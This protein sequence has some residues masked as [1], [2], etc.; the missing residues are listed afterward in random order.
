MFS[1]LRLLPLVFL[2]SWAFAA[3]L[4]TQGPY[5]VDSEGRVVLLRGLNVAGHAKV[6]PFVSIQEPSELDPL[7]DWGMNV[8]RL[9]FTWEAYEPKPG[10]YR[11][12]YLEHIR[13]TLQWAEERGIY[14]IVDF[15]Q[16]AYSRYVLGG[17]GEG[18]PIWTIAPGIPMAY[19]RNDE[20]CKAW[21]LRAGLSPGMHK[22]F[23]EFYRDWNGVKT[24][25]ML[26]AE[27]VARSLHGTPNLIGYDL[28]NE[29]WGKG[30]ELKAFHEE[31]S[32]AVRRGDPESIIFISPQ[33][34]AS[35]GLVDVNF[36]RPALENFAY[37]PH[38]YDPALF[39]AKRYVPWVAHQAFAR[40]EQRA[41]AW[42]VPMIL[43]EFGGTPQIHDIEGYTD[44]LYA[45]LDE[46]YNSGAQWDYTT[47]WDPEA[48]DGWNREDF[49]VTDDQQQL[50][51]N[52]IP[53]PYPQVL[54]GL[55]ESFRVAPRAKAGELW[56]KL[57]FSSEPEKGATELYIPGNV[58]YTFRTS[59]G[60]TCEPRALGMSCE[61]SSKG[62]KTL[63]LWRD[64]RNP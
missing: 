37:S 34:E 49:S 46:A 15:H 19:P 50:R 52:F 16:D 24:R 35:S 42:G 8:M 41:Q 5:F 18:F 62:L 47:K 43:G 48:K 25:F 23:S 1:L 53:R 6:P 36:D 21:G 55:P 32:A 20:G 29:P 60:L 57:I 14:A 17:C 13:Q 28:M 61:A 11:E 3:P 9:L 12:D 33:A 56:L 39:L 45:H 59:E 27:R 51:S 44:L 26:M 31:A 4:R 54:A 2:S 38:F 30:H 64:G 10:E 63:E 40:M 22:A 7:R 58:P